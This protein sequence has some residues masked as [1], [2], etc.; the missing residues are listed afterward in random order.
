MPIQRHWILN[1]AC[2]YDFSFFH[3][4][5]IPIE[6]TNFEKTV[7]PKNVWMWYW[8]GLPTSMFWSQN[9]ATN[10]ST[11]FR[12]AEYLLITTNL[13]TSYVMVFIRKT[14]LN[15]S[16]SWSNSSETNSWYKLFSFLVRHGFTNISSFLC[17][18]LCYASYCVY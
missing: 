1:M 2:S 16:L 12:A 13:L 17:L 7:G 10:L 11:R 8:C 9:Q 5:V 15:S 18:K 3:T 14:I 6:Y 4:T